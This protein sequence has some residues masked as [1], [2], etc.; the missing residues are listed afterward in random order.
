MAEHLA[1]ELR[2]SKSLVSAHLLVPGWTFTGMTGAGVGGGDEDAAA[3]AAPEKPA[4]AWTADQVVGYM[5]DK[6]DR[7]EFY[8]ICPD[9]SVDTATDNARMQW[10][11]RRNHQP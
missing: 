9:N 11:V 3:A 10:N 1:W 6:V 5:L 7:G 8:I 2:E 4:G